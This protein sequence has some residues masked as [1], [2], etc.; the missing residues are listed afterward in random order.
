M[1][2]GVVVVTFVQFIKLGLEL[3]GRQ[4]S[5]ILSKPGV[6]VRER[7]VTMPRAKNTTGLFF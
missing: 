2:R 5:I 7:Q 1:S 6:K 4:M 3:S